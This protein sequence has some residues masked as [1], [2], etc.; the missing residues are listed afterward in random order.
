VRLSTLQENEVARLYLGG[1]FRASELAERYGITRQTVT[2]IARRRKGKALGSD[3]PQ[4]V[5]NN[6]ETPGRDPLQDTPGVS[7][8]L[9]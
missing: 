7:H 6:P 3:N 9:P 2:K 5:I 1:F 4:G 8:D